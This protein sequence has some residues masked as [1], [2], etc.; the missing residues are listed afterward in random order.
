MITVA[1]LLGFAAFG[2]V[3]LIIYWRVA[4][5]EAMKGKGVD[6]RR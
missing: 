5:R 6:E 1:V 4:D 3:G 2:A